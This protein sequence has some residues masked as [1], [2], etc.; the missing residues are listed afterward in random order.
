MGSQWSYYLPVILTVHR[1]HTSCLRS[2]Q[3]SLNMQSK[4]AHARIS[5]MHDLLATKGPCISD[6]IRSPPVYID[7]LNACHII[8]LCVCVLYTSGPFV[9]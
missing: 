2:T 6:I 5:K 8:I 4:H 1:R 9:A 3:L 7:L